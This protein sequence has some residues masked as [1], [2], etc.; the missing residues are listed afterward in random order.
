MET[1]KRGTSVKYSH[2]FSYGSDVPT[3]AIG[4]Y[5]VNSDL[6]FLVK[7]V[8]HFDVNKTEFT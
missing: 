7:C 6:T 2:M 4:R 5:S 3:V 1:C 8:D